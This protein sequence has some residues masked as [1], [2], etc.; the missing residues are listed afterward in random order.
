MPNLE[1]STRASIWVYL[2]SVR[3]WYF[4]K[5]TYI[6]RI[7]AMTII[8]AFW[9]PGWALVTRISFTLF[10]SRSFDP[11][12]WPGSLSKA[13]AQYL[14]PVAGFSHIN[15]QMYLYSPYNSLEIGPRQDVLGS[16]GRKQ[17][18]GTSV[19]PLRQVPVFLFMARLV[20]F[21]KKFKKQSLLLWS[22]SPSHLIWLEA[23]SKQE[24]L[25]GWLLR[26]CELVRD[27]AT[28]LL[29]LAGG[30]AWEFPSLLDALL[31]CV[32]SSTRGSQVAVCYKQDA[33]PF[34]SGIV[35]MEQGGYGETPKPFSGKWIPQLPVI[36]GVIPGSQPTRPVR[37]LLQN[38]VDVVAKWQSSAQ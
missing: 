27:F 10:V 18:R 7:L 38:L 6:Q 11:A 22:Q 23:L 32:Q 34:G 3:E 17:K 16:W 30:S 25:E 9:R 4:K 36:L 28:K 14:F 26:T 12:S 24:F 31:A 35:E 20:T 13:G 8:E 21:H 2:L 37:E 15:F 1:Y 19:R 29:A 5:I 33:L